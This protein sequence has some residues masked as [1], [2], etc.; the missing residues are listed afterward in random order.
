MT[1]AERSREAQYFAVVKSL[2]RHFSCPFA[3]SSVRQRLP[4][5]D[6]RT[7]SAI[8][9][10]MLATIGLRSQFQI[11]KLADIDPVSLPCILFRKNGD[12]I[13]LDRISSN[14]RTAYFL[15]P[16]VS[17]TVHE[18]STRRLAK[19]L[20]STVLFVGNDNTQEIFD[21][22]EHLSDTP[23]VPSGH[24][25][26]SPVFANQHAWWQILIA[27]ISVNMLG[28][29][30]PLFVMNVYD[31]VI[32]NLAMVT[33]WTLVLGVVIALLMDLLLKLIRTSVLDRTGKRIDLIVS[34]ALLRQSMNIR[35]GDRSA[36]ATTMASQI[37]EFETLREFFT[38]NS[39]VAIID[40]FFIG[41][42]IFVLWIVV[43]PLAFVPLA[44]IPIV[45]VIALVAQ[46]PIRQSIEK[47]QRQAERRHLILIEA[48][49]GLETVKSVNG[50][51]VIQREWENAVTSGAWLSGKSRFWSALVANST[52]FIQQAV[53]VITILWGVYLVAAGTITIGG[54]IAANILAGRILAPLGNI[55]QTLVRAQ[56]SLRAYSAIS[57]LM[58]ERIE[59]ADT[60]KGNLTVKRGD[61]DFANVS[62]VY[63][64][65]R[66][67]A[68]ENVT[69]SVK[70]G[71]A[72]GLLGRVGSGKST[73][74]K[75]LC[76]LVEPTSGLILIDGFEM[77]H[78]EPAVLR[79]GIGY[80]P[81]DPE[82]FTGTIKDNL[83][84]GNPDAS[85]DDIRHAL[86]IAGME[87]FIS[88]NPDGLNQFVGERGSRLSGGQK[89]SIS[90][91]RLI[92]RK[93][94]MMFLD[95]PTNAMDYATEETVISRLKTLR[96]EGVGVIIATHRHSITSI[97][98]RLIVIDGGRIRLDGP[99]DEILSRISRPTVRAAE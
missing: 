50:E 74:G 67:P 9:P 2:A 69:F 21:N 32:P 15:D 30:L 14:R 19:S 27:T 11:R 24:W 8:L 22:A 20:D 37:R 70:A 83:L 44:A 82:L 41:I 52:I 87:Y 25:F 98:D 40:L 47:V 88:Q 63:P 28:L 92:L 16:A 55:A 90:I 86:N 79:D 89:Q 34:S 48:L 36:S 17:S 91:A 64:G 4:L 54:L 56:Q 65:A 33:L 73:I 26:W 60:V 85:E 80:L 29:A 1:K 61:I 31:R 35:L 97:V 59:A 18:V 93:P 3:E 46:A 71:E 7:D 96:T 84:L 76:G 95:E 5:I 75:L 53:S 68:L 78:Y 23:A 81:Q 39:F 51:P 42:F 12:P 10:R 38:S 77:S 58:Q 45:I 99:R 72:V 6:D 62:V 66:L 43:G 94:R 13:I 57:R 49:I